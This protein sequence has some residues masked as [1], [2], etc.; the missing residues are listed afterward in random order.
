MTPEA[1]SSWRGPSAKAAT[2]PA[3]SAKRDGLLKRVSREV[4]DHP[5]ETLAIITMGIAAARLLTRKEREMSVPTRRGRRSLRFAP[6][7]LMAAICMLMIAGCEIMP[8]PVIHVAPDPDTFTRV[9]GDDL[10]LAGEVIAREHC[11]SCHGVDEPGR[12]GAPPLNT[13]VTRRGADKLADDLVAGLELAHRSMPRFD[14]NV[15]AEVALM[16]YLEAIAV[17]DTTGP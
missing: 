17:A 7:G 12:A 10:V 1:P 5:A 3:P 6:I 13:V 4:A 16:A 14:F 15:T 2:P 8:R 11:V 9:Y